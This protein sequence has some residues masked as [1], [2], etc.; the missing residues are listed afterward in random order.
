MDLAY[1]DFH[2]SAPAK[3]QK[4]QAIEDKELRNLVSRTERLLDEANCLQH[5][6]TATISHLQKNPEAMAAVALTLAEISNLARKMAPGALAA[7]RTSAPAVWALLASPQF[8]IAAGVGLGV[9]VVAFGSYKIIKR[10]QSSKDEGAVNP[11]GSEDMVELNTEC[12]SHVEQWRRGVADAG[13]ESVGTSVEG[14]FI[15]PTAAAMSRLDLN[16]AGKSRHCRPKSWAGES[17][18][19]SRRSR[20]LRA[21]PS[22]RDSLAMDGKSEPRVVDLKAG[23]SVGPRRSTSNAFS[24]SSKPPSKADSRSSGKEKSK[25]KEKKTGPSRLRQMFTPS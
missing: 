22:N 11:R 21:H 24:K 8:L 6:A 20:R 16:S 17:M 7:L 4:P 3:P 13:A 1:G 5:T 15:T 12:L 19:S 25:S 2:P 23:D 10:I 14:E 18:G 9:T